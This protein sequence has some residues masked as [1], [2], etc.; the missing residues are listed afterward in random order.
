MITYDKDIKISNTLLAGYEVF[1]DNSHPLHNY[2]GSVYYHRHLAS[3][4]KGDWLTPDE[5]VHHI[6]GN[7]RNN[8]F[9]NISILTKKEHAEIEAKIRGWEVGV[10]YYCIV[11]KKELNQGKTLKTGMCA[12]CY[13]YSTRM[14]NPTKEDLEKLVWSMPTTSVAR[15]FGVSDNAVGKR[16][17]ELGIE[18]PKRGYWSKVKSKK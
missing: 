15:L 2:N 1:F 14:F 16:C 7:K 10:I 6:D 18:K 4:K 3:I 17:K 8:T 5:H 13:S 9:E 12:K 11:C